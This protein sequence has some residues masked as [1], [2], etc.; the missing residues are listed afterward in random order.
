MTATPFQFPKLGPVASALEDRF[1]GWLR[2]VCAL[3][4]RQWRKTLP[5]GCEMLFGRIDL[6]RT[7]DVL[8]RL[9]ETSVA[10]RVALHER[11]PTLLVWP[12]PLL[13]GIV[14]AL[15]GAGASEL[16]ADR[17]VTLIEES[18][19]EFFLKDI[20]LPPFLETWGGRLPIRP[21]IEGKEANPRWSRLFPA[22]ESLLAT[23]LALKA[24]FGEQAW[25]WLVP[26]RGLTECFWQETEAAETA[27]VARQRLESA[28]RELPVDMT[29]LLGSAELRLTQ[30]AQLQVGDVI[31][32]DQRL[33]QPLAA[34]VGE[35]TKFCGWPGRVGS[36]QVLQ[37]AEG[38][39]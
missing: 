14:N 17:E 36:R 23:S 12:R 16:P 22:D 35:R 10:Y 28:V 33:S 1:A 2:M 18:L 21:V 29:V 31:V 9:E 30:L 34:R 25:L 13:L 15:Q 20:L 3:A 27:A 26:K 5:G 19:F 32:L 11:L 6:G 8:G 7:C 24:G 38:D 37:I 39:A 4:T